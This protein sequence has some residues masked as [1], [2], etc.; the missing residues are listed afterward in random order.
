MK[1]KKAVGPD[2]VPVKVWKILGDASIR[3]LKDLF[4]NVNR[5]EN[6]RRLEKL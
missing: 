6:A 1:K 2:G 5:G 3:W 4:N